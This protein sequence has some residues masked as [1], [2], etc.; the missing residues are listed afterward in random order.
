M[1][2]NVLHQRLEKEVLPL[3]AGRILPFDITASQAYAESM[4]AARAAGLAVGTAGGT[5]AAIAAANSLIV[6]TRETSPFEAA[7]LQVIN[8]WES[9]K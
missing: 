3:F 7:G 9:E 1:R 8:P 5:I 2:R 4:A 6:A